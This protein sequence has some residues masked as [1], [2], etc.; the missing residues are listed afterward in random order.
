L[1]ICSKNCGITLEDLKVRRKES[2]KINP[3][4]Q[5]ANPGIGTQTKLKLTWLYSIALKYG[6]QILKNKE[7]TYFYT[8]FHMGLSGHIFP[9]Y[10]GRG[11]FLLLGRC[12]VLLGQTNFL[13]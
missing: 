2:K 11:S 5:D 10:V 6:D 13:Q 4:N 8:F 7:G 3:S 1:N 12:F 9:D